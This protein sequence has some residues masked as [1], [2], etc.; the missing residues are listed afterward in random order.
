MHSK[1]TISTVG[2]WFKT[3]IASGGI[4]RSGRGTQLGLHLQSKDEMKDD[5][6]LHDCSRS[7]LL[8]P[9]FFLLYNARVVKYYLDKVSFDIGKEKRQIGYPRSLDL[10]Q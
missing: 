5:S 4:F 6:P 2:K 1:W 7:T 3:T 8:K 9:P 10:H